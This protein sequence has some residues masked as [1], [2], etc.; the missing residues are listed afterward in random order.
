MNI[1]LIDDDKTNA[2]LLKLL[3]ELDG[4]AVTLAPTLELARARLTPEIGAVV[5]DCNLAGGVSGL[6]LVEEIRQGNTA[7]SPDL[8]IFA[9]SGDDRRAAEAFAQAP[10]SSTLNPSPPPIYPPPSAPPSPHDPSPHRPTRT[11][12]RTYS[13]AT[14]P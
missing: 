3:L 12:Y 7:V 10:T 4:F 13:T 9:T 14:R 6:T 2:D 11:D 1:L 8:I 5:V